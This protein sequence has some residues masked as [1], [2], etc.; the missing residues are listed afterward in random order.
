VERLLAISE[1]AI[2]LGLGWWAARAHEA[3]EPAGVAGPMPAESRS[4]PG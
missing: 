2:L 3:D 4:G 1:V